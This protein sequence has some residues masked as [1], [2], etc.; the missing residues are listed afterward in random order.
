MEEDQYR[1]TY[2]QLNQ[3]RCV[4]E[5]AILSRRASC[6]Q[7]HKFCLAEREGVSCQS[8]A[9]QER[10]QDFLQ[11]ARSKALF[12]LKIT[13]IDGAL[14]H[15]KEIR[16]QLGGLTGLAELLD[17][18]DPEE[19]HDACELVRSAANRYEGLANLPYD[20]IIRAIMRI[21]GRRRRR[22]RS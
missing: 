13:H 22:D 20:T 6:A 9:D 3:T 15:A 21:Q 4:F 17:L 8:V 11:A 18:D 7:S 16:V 12:A 10:C 19:T 5:K 1:A 14:P 2:Q